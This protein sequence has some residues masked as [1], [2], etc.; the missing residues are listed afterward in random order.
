MISGR[1]LVAAIAALAFLALTLA[2]LVARKKWPHLDIPAIISAV[3][4]V[5]AVIGAI[6]LIPDALVGPTPT[7]TPTFAPTPMPTPTLTATPAPTPTY[8]PTPTPTPL[9]QYEYLDGFDRDGEPDSARWD[10][11]GNACFEVTQAQDFLQMRCTQIPAEAE[12]VSMN[13][14][15]V[16]S[17][18]Q[19][20]GIA[21]LGRVEAGN[22]SVQAFLGIVV[23][24]TD[25]SGTSE[26]VRYSLALRE[27]TAFVAESE[28]GILDTKTVDPD[29]FHTLRVKHFDRH[30]VFFVDDQELLAEEPVTLPEGYIWSNW[31]LTAK[32]NRVTL[33]DDQITTWID[34]VQWIPPDLE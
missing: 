31:W 28:Q 7:L 5:A 17:Y 34:W 2:L 8:T 4:G 25:A 26:Q 11:D 23:F 20:Q 13:L 12:Y 3:A 33:P 30:L 27:K 9:P 18:R 6:L 22:D 16:E 14:K 32:I 24:F 19:A 29:M 1:V 10:E 15:P 21:I